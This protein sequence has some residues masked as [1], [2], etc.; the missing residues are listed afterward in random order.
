MKSFFIFICIVQLISCKSDDQIISEQINAAVVAL[1]N[2]EDKRAFL[3]SIFEE[4]I[5]MRLKETEVWNEHGR[6]SFEY[7]AIVSD[8]RSTDLIL[9]EK[10]DVYM[11]TFGYPSIMQLGQ[12]AAVIS[13]AH[14][15]YVGDEVIL[16]K[17][18]NYFYDA[19]KFNDITADLYYEYLAKLLKPSGDE[20]RALFLDKNQAEVIEILQDRAKDKFKK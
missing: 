15:T 6:E 2:N 18:F 14:I 7:E 3:E 17:N 13:I 9:A 8:N 1:E 19:Y 10:L 12:K 11:N 5:E 4:H 20:R 16:E